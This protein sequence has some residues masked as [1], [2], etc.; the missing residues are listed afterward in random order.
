MNKFFLLSAALLLI[1]VS[2]TFGRNVVFV[3]H[4]TVG[5]TIDL[6][7]KNNYLLFS[8]FDLGQSNEFVIRE[9]NEGFELQ[10]FHN[11]KLVKTMPL[12]TQEVNQ[13]ANNIEKINRYWESQVANDSIAAESL[14]SG[15]DQ[16]AYESLDLDLISPVDIKEIKGALKVEWHRQKALERIENIKKGHMF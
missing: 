3:L 13:Y 1:I 9:C 15:L 4:S 6:D 8:D 14:S 16:S 5:D 2:S 10:G 12:T 7:E 11:N